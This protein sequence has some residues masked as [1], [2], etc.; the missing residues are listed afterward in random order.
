VKW[1][2]YREH[3]LEQYVIKHVF[4][5]LIQLAAE[6]CRRRYGRGLREHFSD[7]GVVRAVIAPQI[8]V[9]GHP[10]DCGAAVIARGRGGIVGC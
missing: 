3:G 1:V 7:A 5:L 2:T 8:F 9:A 4:E 10:G 6:R